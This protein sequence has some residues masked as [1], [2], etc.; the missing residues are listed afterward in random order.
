[1]ERRG[2]DEIVGDVVS[3]GRKWEGGTSPAYVNIEN[4]VVNS[5]DEITSDD[6]LWT[7]H[8]YASGGGDSGSVD[9][10]MVV[11]STDKKNGRD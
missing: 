1:M 7:S 9:S 5:A 4:D 8:S 6:E 2:A 11:D 10:G 3:D